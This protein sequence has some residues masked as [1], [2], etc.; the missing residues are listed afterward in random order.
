MDKLIP[1][2]GVPEAILSDRGANFLSHL[3]MDI[4][5]LLG[6]HKLNTSVYHPQCNGMVERFNRTLKGMLGAHAA[7]FGS[8]W[9]LMLSGVLFAYQNTPHESTCEKLSFLAFG[10]DS[11]TPPE[12]AW[13][14]SAPLS[15]T[16]LS[17]YWEQLIGSLSSARELAASQIPAA[18]CWSKRYYDQATGDPPQSWSLDPYPFSGWRN[19]SKVEVITSLAWFL[20]GHQPR[21]PE[22]HCHQGV[23]PTGRCTASPPVPSA[24]GP[25]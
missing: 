1:V 9:D 12:S 18:Q 4:C 13:M 7:R 14:S 24:P 22:Y 11:R 10:V 2:F 15:P 8:Q 3:M 25:Q 6:I 23:L 20:S 5:E 17:D 19:W 21:P 16:T